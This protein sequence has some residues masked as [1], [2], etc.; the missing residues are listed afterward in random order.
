MGH[1]KSSQTSKMEFLAET[2]LSSMFECASA[3]LGQFLHVFQ[4]VLLHVRLHLREHEKIPEKV[5]I[6]PKIKHD[7]HMSSAQSMW[8]INHFLNSISLRSISTN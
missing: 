1:S 3:S 4:I 7:Q 5:K 8:D 2:T 6:N